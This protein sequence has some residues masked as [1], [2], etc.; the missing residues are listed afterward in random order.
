MYMLASII[1][2]LEIYNAVHGKVHENEPGGWP[3]KIT[4]WPKA[5]SFVVVV[6][7]IDQIPAAA[8]KI[9]IDPLLFYDTWPSIERERK[10]SVTLR[11]FFEWNTERIETNMIFQLLRKKKPNLLLQVSITSIPRIPILIGTDRDL[12]GRT[13]LIGGS[14]SLGRILNEKNELFFF[15][16]S[17][18]LSLSLLAGMNMSVETIYAELLR[19]VHCFLSETAECVSR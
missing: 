7:L 14:S 6:N 4:Y 9:S 10:N 17:I 12:N 15:F 13:P 8:T 11:W 2:M 19:V 1:I 18:H 16:H 3:L 5:T